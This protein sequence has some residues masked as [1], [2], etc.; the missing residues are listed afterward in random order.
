MN[1]VNRNLLK[2]HAWFWGSLHQIL[3]LT[4]VAVTG[5]AAYFVVYGEFLGKNSFYIQSVIV[6]LLV[7]QV[8]FNNAALYNTWRYKSI[9]S[10]CTTLILSWVSVMSLLAMSLFF[11]GHQNP[12]IH[13]WI[14][15]WFISGFVVLLLER[16]F[17]RLLLR[18]FRRHGLNL[19]KVMLVGISSSC[20]EL[21]TRFK[22]YSWTGLQIIQCFNVDE[23]SGGF[24]RLAIESRIALGDIDQLW[25]ALPLR[26]EA[27]IRELIDMCVLSSVEVIYVPDLVSFNLVNHSVS[28]VAGLPAIN[29]TSIRLAGFNL[30][31]KESLDK[32]L[33]LIVLCLLWPIFLLIAI[34]IKLDSPGSV[35]YRQERLGARGRVFTV[36]KFR[37]MIQHK[38]TVTK[39]TQATRHDHRVTRIG[40]LLRRTS[41]DELPQFLNVLV[42]DMSIVGPRPH[43]ILHNEQYKTQVHNYMLRHRVKPGITGW[44]QINGYRGETDTLDKMKNRVAYDL[45]YIE[46]WSFGLDLKIMA[47]TILKG[48]VHQNAY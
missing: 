7:S 36:L 43:A 48:F 35:F 9:L 38:E 47:M 2:G 4:I 23:V 6:T 3:E 28:E 21:T 1:L 17:L 42:G 29:L 30:M 8:L 16:L 45:Y 32:L 13:I 41:L 19:R 31:I 37:T 46:H 44:A 10:E 39:L 14:L 12:S 5:A 15:D 20:H 22:N 11:I 34:A 24:D 26:N 33:S 40:Q 27:T 18:W 25:I